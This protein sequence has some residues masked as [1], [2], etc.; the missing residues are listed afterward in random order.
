MSEYLDPD[1]DHVTLQ[2]KVIFDI[3]YHFGNDNF[4]SMTKDIFMVECDQ[5]TGVTYVKMCV[6]KEKDSHAMGFMPE[7]KGSKYCPVRSFRMYVKHLDPDLPW[8]WQT[9]LSGR[10]QEVW[11]GK[12]KKGKNG[13]TCF[14]HH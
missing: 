5:Q 13:H 6:G 14:L 2:N 10:K 4:I 9:P 8:L 12:A 7:I 3:R 11:Y 1:N